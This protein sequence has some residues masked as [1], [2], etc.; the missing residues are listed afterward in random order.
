MIA[1]LIT[2]L[3]SDPSYAVSVQDLKL[4]AEYTKD[5]GKA[6]E[7]PDPRII[8]K[9]YELR[10]PVKQDIELRLYV[11]FIYIVMDRDEIPVQLRI[12]REVWEKLSTGNVKITQEFVA[13]QDLDGNVDSGHACIQIQTK[14]SEILEYIDK[15][16]SE[17]N[18]QSMLDGTI[19]LMVKR[20][21]LNN[22][23]I[24]RRLTC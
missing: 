22:M 7:S 14:E 19:A 8:I 1:F 20:L 13:D 4:A 21:G 2:G 6:L 18:A 15:D 3:F 9:Y 12:V 10:E 11:A 5:N 16:L 17:I 23:K 24:W